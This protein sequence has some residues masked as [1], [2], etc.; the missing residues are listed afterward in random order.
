MI[1]MQAIKHIGK[2]WYP[3]LVCAYIS[4]ACVECEDGGI[5]LTNNGS[6]ETNGSGRVEVCFNNSYGLVCNDRWDEVDA[7]VVC[8]QLGMGTSS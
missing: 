6:V 7:A 2:G 1:T 3:F 4:F 5:L 8:R